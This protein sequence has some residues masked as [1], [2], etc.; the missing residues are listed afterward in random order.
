MSG[1]TVARQQA[2][3]HHW[4]A[5]P[6]L[7]AWQDTLTTVHMWSQI[8]GKIRLTRAP[9]INHWWGTALYLTTRGLTTS[10]IPHGDRT[11]SIDLDFLDHALHIQTSDGPE[12]RFAL[13]PMSVA[14]FYRRIMSALAELNIQVQIFTRPVEVEQA[15]PFEADE[16]HA[17]Y[18]A[19][20]V[21]SFWR[22]MVQADRVL[23]QF[24]S[25]FIGKVS[26]VHFFWGGFDLA[27][28]RFSGRLAPRH[29]GGIPNCANWVM[30]E[31]YSHEVSSAGFWAGPGLGEPA[32]YSYAY[33]SPPG[34]A[35]APVQPAAAYFH[36]KLGEFVL[37]Y[38]S[39]RAAADPD[40]ALMAFLQST[41]AAA[42]QLG[43]WDR[44][45]LER[46]AA[47]RAG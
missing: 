17:S 25:L 22:A 14:A 13:E 46:P 19:Q 10:A 35:R 42:A 45:A 5:L 16:T 23:T 27:V 44:P 43:N 29:P 40:A 8:I 26:P 18:D 1:P 15:I 4:P 36:E 6:P 21:Q 20:A 39:V 34:F 33:P 24:R 2:E 41:Y 11:F 3:T 32:F 30:E 31:A 9:A 28:T 47:T 37:P 7:A 12:H 38:E